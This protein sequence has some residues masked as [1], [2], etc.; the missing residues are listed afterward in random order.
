MRYH[1][2][3]LRRAIIKKTRKKCW[4]D[5]GEKRTLVHCWW[6]CKLVQP[7]WKKVWSFFKKLKLQ[8]PHDPTIPLL[9]VYWKEMKTLIQKDICTLMFIAALLTKA[10]TWKQS[11]CPS[12]D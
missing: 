6:E 5:N 3:P 2:I 4:Q 12:M 7:L 11:K 8:L 9:G 10:K 1:L